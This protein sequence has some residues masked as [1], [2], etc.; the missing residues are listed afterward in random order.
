[1]NKKTGLYIG[2]FQP[3]HLGHLSIVKRALKEVDH[4]IIGIGSAQ[5]SCQER[6]PFNA[7]ERKKII[8]ISLKEAHLEQNLYTIIEID[9]INNEGEWTQHVK[10]L[11][12]PFEIIFTGDYGIVKELFKKHT[13]LPVKVFEEEI[14]VRATSI[15]KKIA[16]NTNWQAL[17]STGAAEYLK[18]I[19][20]VNRIKCL[21]AS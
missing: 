12:P 13:N 10:N 16:N 17:V 5:Y 2:R 11:T 4:L 15:R 19:G 3:F 9:D 18:L 21:L 6:N 1:M 7:K 8:E 14:K 20:G